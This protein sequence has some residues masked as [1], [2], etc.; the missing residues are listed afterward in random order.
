M[1]SK[2]TV[3]AARRSRRASSVGYSGNTGHSTGPH[4]HLEI[5]PH[6]GDPVDPLPW[7][8]TTARAVGVL[9]HHAAARC[10]R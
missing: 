5:H 6:G 4:L 3:H 9:A 8:E 10:R 7:L 1:D 2:L